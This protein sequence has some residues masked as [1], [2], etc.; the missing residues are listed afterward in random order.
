MSSSSSRTIRVFVSSTFSDMKVERDLLQRDVFPRVRQFCL[1]NGFRFQPIDLRWG[2]PEEAGRDNRTVRICLRELKRCQAGGPKP[3]FL[4]LLGDRY[5]WRPL[6]EAVPADLF[7]LLREEIPPSLH[8]LLEWREDQPAA[9]KGWYRRDDNADPPVFEL[10]PRGDD[11]DWQNKV[12]RPLLAALERAARNLGLES[13]VG[14]IAIGSSAT[15]QEI[16]HGA[17]RV[18]DAADHVHAFVRTI[19]NLPEVPPPDFVDLQ[20]D[21]TPDAV[22]ITRLEDLKRRIKDKIGEG[23]MHAYSASLSGG[24]IDPASLAEFREKTYASLIGVIE[25][26]V[27]QLSEGWAAEREETAHRVFGEERC[28][29]FLGRTEPLQEIAECLHGGSRRPLVISGP[30]GSGKSAFMAEAARR[31]RVAHGDEAVLARF[32]GATPGSSD[33]VSL[34]R[35]AVGAVRK[36]YLAPPPREGEKSKDGEIPLEIQPLMVVFDE[37]IRR[38]T[39]NRPLIIFLDALDQLSSANSARDLLWLPATLPEHVRLVVSCAQPAEDLD[40]SAPAAAS[41]PRVQVENALRQR[42]GDS[43]RT[44]LSPLSRADGEAL[45]AQWLAL[46]GRKLQE[47]QSDAVLAS[48]AAEGKPLWLRAA[49]SECSNLSAWAPPP[50]F[51]RS[52]EGLL[53]QVLERLSTEAEHGTVMVERAL[54]YL[55]CARHGLAEDEVM[56]LL[57]ADTEVMKDFRRRSPTER[58]KSEAEH[59]KTLPAAVWVRFHGD[60]APYLSERGMQGASLFGFYHRSFLEAVEAQCL[61]DGK[62]RVATHER[63][64][65]YFEER[66]WFLAPA[67]E[68]PSVL[69]RKARIEDPPNARK[70]SELPWHLY[71]VADL[72]DSERTNAEAWDPLTAKLCD[73]L[74]IEAKARSGLVREMQ[75]DYRLALAALPETQAQLAEEKRRQEP[76]ARWTKEIIEYSRKWSERRDQSARGQAAN[77][78]EPQLPESPPSCR[79]WT[80]DEIQ[81]ECQRIIQN[82][83][84]LDRLRAFAGFVEQECFPLL[85]FGVRTGFA[86]QHAF[87]HAPAGPVHGEAKKNADSVATPILLRRWPPEGVYNPKPALL[88]TLEG[89]SFLVHGVAVSADGR[90]AVSASQD[91]TLKVWDVESGRE[92]R[93]LQGHS[94]EVNDVAVSA[95]GRRAVSA[96]DDKTLKVW[97]V[98]S[99]RELRTLEGHSHLVLGVAVSADG[100]LAVSASS[101]STLKVWDVESGHELRTLEGH[102]DFVRGVAVSADG[103]RAVSASD[104]KTLKVWDVESGRELRT[105]QGHSREVNDVAVSADGRRAVS[106]SYDSTLKVWDV[107]SGRELRTLEGHSG[108]VRGVAV[109]ADG[110]RAVSASQDHTLKVWD[111][112]SGHE[113]RTLEGHSVWVLGVAMSAD[114]RRA[115]SASDDKTLKVWDVETGRELRTLQGH[116]SL[117]NGVA[118]SA[119]GRRAVSASWDD[120]LK[121]WDVESGH[122]LRTLQGHS[123][124]VNDVAV[125]AD[126]RLAVSASWDKTLKVWDVESGRELRTLEGHSGAV[127]GV[128]VS[129]DGQCAVSASDD[130]TLRVWNVETGARLAVVR[131]S[132][133]GTAVALSPARRRVIAGTS[134]GEVPFFDLRG[135]TFGPAVCTAV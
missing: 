16:T 58:L 123:R 8:D 48:F 44:V 116:S 107:E 59:I 28:R 115:V 10:R 39:A 30:A 4:I 101:D 127:C 31:A 135:V 85:E 129:A 15:E 89:H 51:P 54:G 73:L 26:Q 106:A 128:A 18:D 88:R 119:D 113:L 104:D 19:G 2:V 3:N 92:L 37:A 112:E 83:T 99:G 49:V 40:A 103:R 64:A 100:R 76:I 98:E 121:V 71:R 120:T 17:L 33:I 93:T 34:L 25:K 6:P 36:R 46:N 97:D 72:R 94:R 52:T 41:D 134:A 43:P 124:Q 11:A 84:R 23:N 63:L 57:S 110:R 81:A 32:I 7:L 96:S 108:P 91:H 132:A 13:G 45:L 126:G 70:A 35:D 56:D 50:R 65:Q 24:G 62:G 12:E 105:L 77:E 87:N 102:F 86:V 130:Q 60:I 80:E 82:P 114:G 55:A 29:G 27:A 42:L 133:N 53:R 9:A 131:L 90:R 75:E 68:D 117:I 20:P 111:V 21:G 79:T 38:A 5:G 14:D 47:A 78:P 66:E 125:S 122:E 1:S 69:P 118:V 74:L 22:S 109:S 61:P 67:S 95:D